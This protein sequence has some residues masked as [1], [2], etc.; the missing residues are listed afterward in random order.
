MIIRAALASL[1]LLSAGCQG[2]SEEDKL[3]ELDNRIAANATDPAIAD[4][5]EDQ[6]AVDPALTQQSDR[7]AARAT[8]R[9]LEAQYPVPVRGATV[10]REGAGAAPCGTRFQY[11]PS[12]AKRLP[13]AFPLPAGAKLVEAA[14]DDRPQC[15]QRAVTYTTSAAADRVIGWYRARAAAAGFSAEELAQNG[16][17]V[18]GGTKGEAA[19]YLIVTPQPSGSQVA[20]IANEGR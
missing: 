1:L 5:L 6:I 18:L 4:A 15:R 10:Q 2:R 14:G 9:P 3:A 11:D 13:E 8:P 19:Y 17:R 20:L 7:N 12:W 16:D